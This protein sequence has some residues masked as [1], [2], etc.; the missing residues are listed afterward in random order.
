[1]NCLIFLLHFLE[2]FLKPVFLFDVSG[3]IFCDLTGPGI[4]AGSDPVPGPSFSRKN[5]KNSPT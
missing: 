4:R 1:M 3:N 2:F 5:P